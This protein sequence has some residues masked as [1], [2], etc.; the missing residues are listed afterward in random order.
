MDRLAA[1]VRRATERD[2]QAICALVHSERLNPSGIDWPNFLVA[3]MEGRIIGAVQ[4]R[5]HADGSRELGSLVVAKEARGQGVA[6]RMIDALLASDP[7]P[8]WL[9]TAAPNAGAYSRWGFKQIE[10]RAAPAK[11][12]RNHLLGSLARIISFVMRRPMRRLVILERRPRG[13]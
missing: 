10:T 11:V 3:A 2:Q 8:V 12:R 5:K 13:E 9:I 6:S 1:V 7:N 4:I